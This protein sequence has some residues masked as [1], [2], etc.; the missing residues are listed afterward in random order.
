ML[1]VAA[2]PSPKAAIAS[3][4][5]MRKNTRRHCQKMCI[6][7]MLTRKVLYNRNAYTQ[8]FSFRISWFSGVLNH[9]KAFGLIGDLPL[10]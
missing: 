4:A 7:V 6:T 5:S 8:I 9:D 3:V 1:T 10:A 2:R